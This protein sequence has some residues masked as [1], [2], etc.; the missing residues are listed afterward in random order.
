MPRY[1]RGGPAC[2]LGGVFGAAVIMVAKAST[3]RQ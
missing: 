1:L 3:K 2:E